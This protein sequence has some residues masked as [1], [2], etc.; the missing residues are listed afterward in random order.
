MAR[1]ELTTCLLASSLWT[2]LNTE[3]TNQGIGG[4]H[5]GLAWNAKQLNGM[6]LC[7]DPESQKYGQLNS[8]TGTCRWVRIG[9]IRHRP[10]GNN[11]IL[12]LRGKQNRLKMGAL[13][14]PWKMFSGSITKSLPAVMYDISQ[15]LVKKH[16]LIL[17]NKKMSPGWDK[18]SWI[19]VL[20]SQKLSEA[21]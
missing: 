14:L 18:V 10:V 19:V 15:C 4:S 16:C 13:S 8:W 5:A 3:R 20:T 6:M 11:S 7:W 1:Q 12:C 9:L 2:S 21:N 17:C